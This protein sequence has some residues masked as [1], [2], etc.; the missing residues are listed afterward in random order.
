[1]PKPWERNW[2]N[3][4]SPASAPVETNA[5]GKPWERNWSNRAGASAATRTAY[6]PSADTQ[7]APAV[8]QDEG[9]GFLSQVGDFLSS[10]GH[11]AMNMPHGVAQAI[12]NVVDSGAQLL[13]DNAASRAIHRVVA[14]DNEA[15]RQR[16]IDYQ[17]KVPTNTGSVIGAV[18]GEVA[19]MLTAA[20]TR[21]LGFIGGAAEKFAASHAPQ[22]AANVVGKAA[23]GIA[24]GAA[25]GAVAPVTDEDYWKSKGN[26]VALG[27]V[28]APVAQGVGAAAKFG[29]STGRGLIAGK[30]GRQGEILAKAAQFEE[31]PAVLA[32]QIRAGNIEQV[33]GSLPTT[34][35]TVMN[36]AGLSQLQRTVKN[37]SYNPLAEREAA[38]NTARIAALEEIQ[39]G[40][41]G[42]DSIT[43]RGNAGRVIAENYHAQRNALK[44]A[45]KAMWEH[46]ALND[47]N[48][49]F[50][51]KQVRAALEQH[52]PGEMYYE[53]PSLLRRIANSDQRVTSHQE[54]QKMR[55][56]VGNL[57]KDMYNT[58]QS[59]R[60]A[61]LEVKAA[62]SNIYKDAA[63]SAKE[64]L[65][66]TGYGEHG[67]IYGGLS[68]DPRNAVAHLLNTGEGEVPNAAMHPF[69][70]GI[71][72]I[73][74]NE[75]IGLNHIAARG[76]ENV[77]RELPK[78]MEDGAW[79]SRPQSGQGQTYLGDGVK[80]AA[81][82]MQF[83]NKT[84]QW[85]PTAYDQYAKR[86]VSP[87]T[88]QYS[89]L[90]PLTNIQASNVQ[91]ATAGSISPSEKAAQA[92]NPRAYHNLMTNEQE[93][94][95][96]T[97]RFLTGT[98][99]NRFETGAVSDLWQMGRDGLPKK[100]GAEVFDALFNSR[101]T[102]REN[103]AS[104]GKTFPGNEEVW[105]EARKA[106]LSDLLEKTTLQDGT[107][108]NNKM[109]NYL[110]TRKDA[111]D[112]LF[113]ADQTRTLDNVKNDL[114]RAFRA[115][116]TG[117][118]TG[119]NT[120]QNLMGAGLLDH[121]VVSL[122]A[123]G[124]GKFGRGALESVQ[125]NAK[126]SVMKDVGEAM[127]SPEVAINALNVWEKLLQPNALQRYT[128]GTSNRIIP[129]MVN[130]MTN[131][132]E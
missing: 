9:H 60:A 120:A 51:A 36:N 52:Y 31:N 111:I 126:Q 112:G 26:Q 110:R 19:P 115:E 63:A 66:P 119:S 130:R 129:M 8:V 131:N 96:E 16:E 65:T 67:T 27:A 76:R 47:L 93:K 46:P 108:S 44:E 4:V 100:E 53:A 14:S 74:G 30:A 121:P 83:D 77:L 116:N 105:T 59:G 33:A 90:D 20:V 49:D 102:Q 38:Q 128:D 45:E 70:G 35:Q 41:Q 72:L 84:K 125:S 37:G 86:V 17:K 64:K 1:M 34:A 87:E 123:S 80:E 98:R 91:R 103:I 75:K 7:P 95:L 82:R 73:A 99:K 109:V 62:L 114:E 50:P 88:G 39:P 23:S 79:Y 58:D 25:M 2:G 85:I 29:V 21:P 113:S 124:L 3:E 68:G 11:H 32:A 117:R 28:L 118:A 107:L 101:N 6:T 42:I 104:L 18:V 43:A 48:F 89:N 71:D 24:Q 10:A 13:P 78:L 132:G 54:I 61:A 97:A 106:A 69:A 5:N 127:V 40:A 56:L 57:A 55:E 92:I 15:M 94:L 22:F 122:L 12:E 81:V